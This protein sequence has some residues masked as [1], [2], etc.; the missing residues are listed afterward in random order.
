MRRYIAISCVLVGAACAS[1]D[2]TSETR[3]AV[4]RAQDAAQ[5]DERSDETDPSALPSTMND[6]RGGQG[7]GALDAGRIDAAS[8]LTNGREPGATAEDAQADSAREHDG[9]VAVVCKDASL[10]ASP[11]VQRCNAL[12][13]SV[14]TCREDGAWQRNALCPIET[15]VCVALGQTARCVNAQE[16]FVGHTQVDSAWRVITASNVMYAQR[17]TVAEPVT[18]RALFVS[19]AVKAGGCDLALYA[20]EGGHPGAWLASVLSLP[21]ESVPIGRAVSTRTVLQ[22]GTPYWMSANC[23]QDQSPGQLYQAD[24]P[25]QEA[26]AVGVPAGA[27]PPTRFPMQGAV[28]QPGK[29]Y[30]LFLQVRSLP[31]AHQ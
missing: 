2:D 14:E 6:A 21:I 8:Y 19:S 20:D 23:F 3:H 16:F 22:S 18:V 7:E 12:D 10:S 27:P 11:G 28:H 25:D 15:E 26:Y 13:R 29:A 17:F 24:R 4:S 5:S 9:S 30:S 1:D 31:Q